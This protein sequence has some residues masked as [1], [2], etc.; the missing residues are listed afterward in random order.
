[1]TIYEI[2]RTEI[3]ISNCHSNPKF[4]HSVVASTLDEDA[5]V[6]LLNSYRKH[7]TEDESYQ[8][9]EIKINLNILKW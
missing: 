1:M 2:V 9:H 5:A 8:I 4:N 7:Q 6:K 3:L